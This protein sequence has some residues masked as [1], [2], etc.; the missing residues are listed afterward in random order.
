M[1]LFY[2]P[3]ASRAHHSVQALKRPSFALRSQ[4][5]FANT[6]LTCGAK[7]PGAVAAP[8]AEAEATP[9]TEAE[10]TPAAPGAEAD[11]IDSTAPDVEAEA[12]GTPRHHCW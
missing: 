10:A 5:E 11:A 1:Q 2:F 7:A 6:P 8:E 9:S 3:V 4:V 12:E